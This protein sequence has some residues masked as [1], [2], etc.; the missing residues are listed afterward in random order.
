ML[1]RRFRAESIEKIGQNKRRIL[2][3]D[4]IGGGGKEEED[5]GEGD[6]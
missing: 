6:I 4:K 3:M 1:F 2:M 5:E